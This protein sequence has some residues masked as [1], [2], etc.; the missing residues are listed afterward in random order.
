M[1]YA[2][3]EHGVEKA[4]VEMFFSNHI[5]ERPERVEEAEGRAYLLRE[6]S[7]RFA[8]ILGLSAA[9]ALIPAANAVSAPMD[10]DAIAGS[11]PRLAQLFTQLTHTVERGVARPHLV[12]YEEP[13]RIRIEGPGA[14]RFE[15]FVAD[16]AEAL[17]RNSGVDI[18]LGGTRANLH[19]R[20]VGKGFFS[21]APDVACLVAPG[22]VHW[23]ELAAD[24][25]RY[26]IRATARMTAIDHMTVFIPASSSDRRT[27]S[28][29]LEEI[30]QA[31]GPTYDFHSVGNTIFNDDD[32]HMWP[33][34]FDYL[35]LRVL[36]SPELRTGMSRGESEQAALQV[37]RRVAARSTGAQEAIAAVGRNTR[38]AFARDSAR[39]RAA[40]SS[41]AFAQAGAER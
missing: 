34:E 4:T 13:V 24:P 28:C 36:Y 11:E 40:V 15:R 33:T 39:N 18:A 14:A 9:L 19:V 26:D 20:F 21:V 8:K 17:R 37:L 41:D 1:S 5:Y 27:K 35:M 2:S 3:C 38:N 25:Y 12:R 16:Y 6:I 29:L 10:G 30:A 22:D 23:R 7:A 32:A 31:L